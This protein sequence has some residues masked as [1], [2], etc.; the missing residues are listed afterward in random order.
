M[1]NFLLNMYRRGRLTAAKVWSYC[2]RYITEREAKDIAGDRP[3][4]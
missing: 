3:K 1:Y 4:S 2:P